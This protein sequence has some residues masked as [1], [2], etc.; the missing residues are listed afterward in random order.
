MKYKIALLL[1]EHYRNLYDEQVKK[2]PD[3]M[4]I[5]FFSYTTLDELQEAFLNIQDRYDGFYVSGRIPLQAVRNVGKS[6]KDALICNAEVDVANTYRL[7]IQHLVSPNAVPLSRIGMDFLRYEN[8]MEEVITQNRFAEVVYGYE[9]RWKTFQSLEE[10]QEEEDEI[11]AFYKKLIEENKIDLIIT[12][13]YSALEFAKEYNIP[14]YYVYPSAQAFWSSME[15]LKSSI[16]LRRMQKDKAA[17]ICIDK[18]EMRAN[19]KGTF[20]KI[21]RD[22]ENVIQNLNRQQYNQLILKNGHHNLE[23]YM[24]YSYMSQITKEFTECP[25]YEKLSK[26][27]GYV[28]TIGYGVGANLYQARL[29]AM[30]ASRYGR[31]GG[32]N[33]GGSFF[34]DENENLT[35]LKGG[36]MTAMVKISEEYIQKAANDVKL[37]ARNDCAD[38]GSYECDG[39]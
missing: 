15:S 16:S 35:V 33:T 1:K 14:C 13:F 38:Y 28:G 7:L 29:N 2:T 27:L 31:N 8:N 12:Y 9:K 6:G 25:I 21:D 24:D 20:E 17:V 34:I 19:K 39:N 22:L 30:D 5:D 3:D 23:I 37:S 36:R 11:V 26:E 18:E 32:K 10:I 4:K